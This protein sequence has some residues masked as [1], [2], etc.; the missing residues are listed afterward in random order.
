MFSSIWNET[1]ESG[2]LRSRDWPVGTPRN[3]AILRVS[4][5]CALPEN[6]FSSPNPVAMK[7]SPIKAAA[8]ANWLGRK[9]SNLRIPDP[10]ARPLPLGHAPSVAR[11]EVVNEE[12]LTQGAAETSLGKR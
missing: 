8:L 9:D 1:S 5:G 4:S 12:K 3:S 7:G 10:K 2:N 11:S 6:T